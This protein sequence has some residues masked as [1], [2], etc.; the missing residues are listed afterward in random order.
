MLQGHVA[1]AERSVLCNVPS[2]T[3]EDCRCLIQH[4]R[5]SVKGIGPEAD[6]WSSGA[7]I[8]FVG[9]GLAGKRM[10][11]NN[12]RSTMGCERLV[13]EICE[14]CGVGMEPTVEESLIS[15]R[16]RRPQRLPT[17]SRLVDG[18]HANGEHRFIITK[19]SLGINEQP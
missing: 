15:L 7:L 5:R 10:Q 4:S 17:R 9:Q 8:Q 13:N 18:S 19:E 2:R 14:G 12:D 6:G 16:V 11:V 3:L 1:S